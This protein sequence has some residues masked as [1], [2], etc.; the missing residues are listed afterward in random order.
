[1]LRDNRRN[2]SPP[3]P[4]LSQAPFKSRWQQPENQHQVDLTPE[5]HSPVEEVP[6]EQTRVYQNQPDSQSPAEPDPPGQSDS[7]STPESPPRPKPGGRKKTSQ[8]ELAPDL[9]GQNAIEEDLGVSTYRGL[10]NVGLD[11]NGAIW[12][13]EI[14]EQPGFLFPVARPT[15][16][17]PFR[18]Q[19]TE[20][21]SLSVTP[22]QVI[23]AVNPPPPMFCVFIP[24]Y[25][26]TSVSPL[27]ADERL[28][29]PRTRPR[30]PFS[31]AGH[32][33]PSRRGRAGGRRLLRRR[34]Q[35]P[36]SRNDAI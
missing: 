31:S 11:G 18:R 20:E 22:N 23:C 34:V 27:S 19:I 9:V 1:M 21:A 3:P 24:S 35:R 28:R 8:G 25:E 36:C 32:L 14:T 29:S 7:R 2:E 13:S 4:T 5:L 30:P 12:V 26:L 16:P 17:P 10:A 6:V 33:V 15:T